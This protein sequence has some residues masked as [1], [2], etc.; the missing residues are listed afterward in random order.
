MKGAGGGYGYACLTDAARELESHANEG[1]VEKA[2]IALE[3]L[4]RLCE[5]VRAGLAP[6][7]EPQAA[8]TK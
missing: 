7:P 6:D 4:A 5:R 2:M 3:H 8:R 1:D